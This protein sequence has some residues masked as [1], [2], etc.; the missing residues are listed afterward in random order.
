M[1]EENKN[2]PSKGKISKLLKARKN[3]LVVFNPDNGWA[4]DEMIAF[5]RIFNDL[6]S[7]FNRLLIWD[8]FRAHISD[9]TRKL[10][11]RS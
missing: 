8:A 6:Q 1:S 10:L 2:T 11:S 5:W 9:N 7:S 3:V 4:N